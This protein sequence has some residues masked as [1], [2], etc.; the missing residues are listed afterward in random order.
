[1]VSLKGDSVVGKTIPNKAVQYLKYGKPILGV[2]KGDGKDLLVSAK[3]SIISE[4][5]VE[6]IAS[7]IKKIVSLSNKEKETMGN[8]NLAYFKEHL[9]LSKIV[10]T[11]EQELKEAIE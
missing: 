2:I 6:S 7:N 10:K 1:M 3:G 9:E 8:N 4:G 11:I 5:D